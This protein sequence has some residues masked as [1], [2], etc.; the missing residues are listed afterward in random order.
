MQLTGEGV[1]GAPKDPDEAVRVLEAMLRLAHPFIPFIAEELWQTVAPLAAYDDQYGQTTGYLMAVATFYDM[2]ETRPVG[3]NTVYVCTNISCSLNGADE[4]FAAFQEHGADDPELNIRAFEC[5][6][7]CDIAPMAS[8][9][10]QWVRYSVG[11]SSVERPDRTHMNASPAEPSRYLSTPAASASTP[12]SVTSSG[13][14][15]IPW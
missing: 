4:L 13:Y 1:W 15:P 10:D 11:T 6:G 14:V 2:L 9:N 12:S 8:V 7:G 5:L 3:R